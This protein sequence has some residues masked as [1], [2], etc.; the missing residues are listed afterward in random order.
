MNWEAAVAGAL[1]PAAGM[2]MDD[3]DMLDGMA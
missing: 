3:D 1:C 2:V